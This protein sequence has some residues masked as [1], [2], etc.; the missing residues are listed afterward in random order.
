MNEMLTVF[1][2]VVRLNFIGLPRS[3]KT[4]LLLRLME[5]IKNIQAEKERLISKNLES[6]NAGGIP[7][8]QPST[9]LAESC[10]QVF[11]KKCVSH[12]IGTISSKKWS[13]LK[14][15]RREGNMLIQLIYNSIISPTHSNKQP[16]QTSSN[17]SQADSEEAK[18][19]AS[20]DVSRSEVK[21]ASQSES[22]A[23][24]D[25]SLS[26]E[27]QHHI[28]DDILSLISDAISREDTD[29][30][31]L[32]DYMILLINTDTGGQ[33]EFL[34]LHS[35][36]VDGPSL[37]LLFHRLQD[38]LHSVFETYYT[39]DDGS[40]TR[41]VESR[42]T[43]EEVLFQAL[44]S[45]ACFS[46][47]FL[48]DKNPQEKDSIQSK[49]NQSKSKVM[50]VGTHRDEVPDEADF[51]KKDDALKMKIEDTKFFDKNIIKYAD[52]SK[53]KNVLCKYP[54]VLVIIMTC[55]LP[56]IYAHALYNFL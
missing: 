19:K 2:R 38:D 17:S 35:S 8:E 18:L 29:L 37:N 43:V 34:D 7:K 23:S 14:D 46:G 52:N 56:R 48:E 6:D 5:V 55:M 31:K 10:G 16:I 4:S 32:L 20:E 24:D 47:C 51:I 53:G 50:F 13:I 25:T 1:I 9:G 11:I 12:K 33:A 28:T 39:Y 41:P 44:S 36:L 45:I 15:L 22:I 27:D 49:V 42:L 3:G 26:E 40:S 30:Q 21:G 54:T